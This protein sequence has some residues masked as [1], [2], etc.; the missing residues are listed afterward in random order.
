MASDGVWVTAPT[1]SAV[2]TV[3]DY[4]RLKYY[5]Y[6]LWSGIYMMDKN[7]ARLINGIVLVLGKH[8]KDEVAIVVIRRGGLVAGLLRRLAPTRCA[9]LKSCC[10]CTDT[11][12]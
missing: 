4:C 7:E 9:G 12:L 5:H 2:R 10:P 3:G 8:A 11:I 1:P 6:T